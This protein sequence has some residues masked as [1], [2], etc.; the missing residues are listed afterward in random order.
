MRGQLIYVMVE[1]KSKYQG[2]LWWQN[3][4]GFMPSAAEQHFQL[5]LLF[6]ADEE[7]SHLAV[8]WFWIYQISRLQ[9]D[10]LKVVFIHKQPDIAISDSQH[11]HS[12]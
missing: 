5:E 12:A 7:I 11:R 2:L 4:H 9:N 6:P 10:S 1:R 8:S 3:G